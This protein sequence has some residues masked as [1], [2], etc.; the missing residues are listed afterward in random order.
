ME[1]LI[2][3]DC[4]GYFTFTE[5]D[6]R[7]YEEKGFSKPLRCKPCRVKKKAGYDSRENYG[8]RDFNMRDLR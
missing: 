1:E 2:C 5:S 6:K 7:F 3:K 4:R 8:Q